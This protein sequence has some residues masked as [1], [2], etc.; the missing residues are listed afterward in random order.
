MVR[1][2]L[3]ADGA[4]LG[5]TDDTVGPF[6]SQDR[7]DAARLRDA[8]L[9]ER[10]IIL[11]VAAV[12]GSPQGRQLLAHMRSVTIEQPAFLPSSMADS[13]VTDRMDPV[14]LGFFREGENSIVRWLEQCVRQAME[15]FR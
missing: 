2:F 8:A 6:E 1:E 9:Q 10:E 13:R 11:M 15:G 14:Y 12:F 7:A 3:G 4:T 5:L